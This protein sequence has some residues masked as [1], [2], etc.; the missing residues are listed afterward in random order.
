MEKNKISRQ[1]KKRKKKL[2]QIEKELL[3]ARGEEGRKVKEKFFTE[4][5]KVVFTIYFRILKSYP[6]SNLMGK[7]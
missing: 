7:C 4:A 6:R 5:T 3:E 1:E 2:E